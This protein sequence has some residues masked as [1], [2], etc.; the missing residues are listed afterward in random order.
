MKIS[1]YETPFM[2]SGAT[3]NDGCAVCAVCAKCALCITWFPSING[4][5]LEALIA[6]AYLTE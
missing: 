4:T 5:S 1:I 3:Y 6:L 2:D